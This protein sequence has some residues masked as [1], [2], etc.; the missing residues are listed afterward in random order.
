[1]LANTMTRFGVPLIAVALAATSLPAQDSTPPAPPAPP[2]A[3]P[4]PPPPPA[5]RPPK[6]SSTVITYDDIDRM[7]PSVVTAYDVVQRLRPRWLQAPRPSTQLPGSYSNV[8]TGMQVYVDNQEMGGVP[9]LR[10]L[11]AEQVYTLRFLT[12]AEM[13]AQ[14]GPSSGP[15]IVVTLKR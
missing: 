8:Q 2:A 15:G 11:P 14:F 12:T 13:G 10:S 4:A 1:M 7:R 5:P 3:A 6:S 9:F